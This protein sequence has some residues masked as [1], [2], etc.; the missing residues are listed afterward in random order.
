MKY[1]KV[2]FLFSFFANFYFLISNAGYHQDQKP[3]AFGIWRIPRL[4]DISI[5]AM[6]LI[7]FLF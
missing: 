2:I 1:L 7:I 5:S 6:D 4:Y 3:Q